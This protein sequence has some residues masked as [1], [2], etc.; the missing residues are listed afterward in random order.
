MNHEF[1]EQLRRGLQK[2]ADP[3][4]VTQ[5]AL[6]RLHEQLAR[7]HEMY[8]VGVIDREAFLPTLGTRWNGKRILS[9]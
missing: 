1:R 5:T 3:Q 6:K 4:K 9:I 8:E 7:V 2:T